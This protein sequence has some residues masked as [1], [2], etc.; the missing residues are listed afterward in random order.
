MATSYGEAVLP[1][2]FSFIYKNRFQNA[3]GDGE[4]RQGLVQLGSD[5]AN[6]AMTGIHE[7]VKLD[8]TVIQ[9]V[10]DLNGAIYIL[11]SDTEMWSLA[12]NTTFL[13]PGDL[14]S[15]QFKEKLIFTNGIEKPQWTD[16]GITWTE[17]KA[18]HE[19][20]T[21]TG[22]TSVLAMFDA[23]VDNW[24]GGTN[25]VENDILYNVNM[26]AYAV[27]NAVT[28]AKLTHTEISTAATGIG[29]AVSSQTAGHTYEIIDSLELNIVA[30]NSPNIL[31]NTTTTLPGTSDAVIVASAV[32]DF[33]KTDIRVGDWVRNTTRT[34]LTSV[35]AI[36]TGQIGVHGI[37]GQVAGDSLIFLKSAMPNGDSPHVHYNRLYLL[38]GR[39]KTKVRISGTNDPQDFTRDS[40]SIDTADFSIDT[41]TFDRQ[42]FDFGTLQPQGDELLG[43]A[44]WQRF[45]AFIGRKAIYFYEGTE[46]IGENANLVPV[47]L[48]PQGCVSKFAFTNIGNLLT[49]ASHNGVEG[50]SFGQHALTLDQ[51]QLSFQVNTTLRTTIS[52]TSENNMRMLFYPKRSWMIFKIGSEMWIYN[53][54]PVVVAGTGKAK[55]MGSWHLFNGRFAQMNDYS[56]RSDGNLM[57]AGPAGVVALFDQDNFDDLGDNIQTEYQT[58]WLSMGEPNSRVT[59]KQGRY[60]KPLFETGSNIEY[61]IRAEAAYDAESSE[62]ITVST[63]G[64]TA[65]IGIAIIGQAVIGGSP[66]VNDKYALRWRGE[67]VRFTISTD[68]TVGKDIISNYTVYY[69]ELGKE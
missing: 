4:K 58:G 27:I 7:L 53:N 14:Q 5:V 30:T 28:S 49:F 43:M 54:A 31:D 8:G 63:S 21:M 15:V 55:D 36:A 61:T 66:V 16:D 11:D 50:V 41:N 48:F 67:R 56:V 10:S 38:D 29:I 2:E 33:T 32:A 60:I 24:V 18:L 47:G 64:A 22:D 17:L 20:G 52:N 37:V 40:A 23:D 12:T 13:V 1:V 57:V 35:T 26:D 3:A 39:D 51:E 62:Q 45:L 65:S 44:S 69:T 9:F 6:T 25:V 46:P 34:A 19:V 68:N 42:S 59:T